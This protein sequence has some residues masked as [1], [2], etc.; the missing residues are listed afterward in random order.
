MRAYRLAYDGTGFRGFQRQPHGDTVSDALLDALAALGVTDDGTR[1]P[2]GYAA[3]GR[4]D[5]GV[6]AS[7]QTVAFTA[8]AWLEPAALNAALPEAVRAWAHAEAPSDFHA[9]RE[10][11]RRTYT[12][13]LHAPDADDGLARA[14][15]DR[16]SGRRPVG[17]L[18]PEDDPAERELAVSATRDGAFLVVTVGAGG[19][20]RQLVRRLAT[21]IAAVACGDRELA[22]VDRV[23]APEPLAGPDGLAPAPAEPLV[24]ADV[25][26]PDLAFT[27]D[28]DAVAAAQATYEARRGTRLTGARVASRLRDAVGN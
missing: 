15:C 9:T 24:L 28:A 12:Y 22:F 3:A 1:V 5:A 6:S 13:H 27:P 14:V 2:D 18:T 10:A 20:P 4:T 16:L 21:L 8:P 11:A 7:H 26:Y 19:F 25:V 23:L 17:N